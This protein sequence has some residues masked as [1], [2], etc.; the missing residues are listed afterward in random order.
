MNK[1]TT[2]ALTTL[3]LAFATP[4]QA[5]D[6]DGEK[7][8]R[9]LPKWEDV[10]PPSRDLDTLVADLKADR[11]P[12][13]TRRDLLR[14]GEKALPGYTELAASKNRKA[15]RFAIAQIVE[16]GGHPPAD[17]TLINVF[18]DDDAKDIKPE[19]R[20]E[21]QGLA[22]RALGKSKCKQAMPLLLEALN[23]RD[24]LEISESA[25]AAL[26]DYGEA[27]VKPLIGY[28]RQALQS[29]GDTK[30]DGVIYRAL[31]ALG[32]IGGDKA[33][34]IL[35]EALDTR[36]GRNALALRH[37][38]AIGLGA[39]ADPKTVEPLIIC[40]EKEKDFYVQKYIG[41]TLRA[42]TKEKL[43]DTPQRWRNWWRREGKAWLNQGKK[44]AEPFE[45][46]L[47]PMPKIR[48]GKKKPD[49]GER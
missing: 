48:K 21:I 43:P 13:D 14:L 11:D 27:A 28:Y 33:R 15:Q 10:A 41:R 4:S 18:T 6:D 8:K 23:R 44:E 24:W 19:L 42:I 47:P 22:A 12:E 2:L 45:L 49:G 7:P 16:L 17:N 35:L 29:G 5:Q 34:V 1:A 40:M 32:E 46:E 26:V 30:Q 37:H 20:V 9:R 25:R 36:E 38:A 39:L 31:L 3:V